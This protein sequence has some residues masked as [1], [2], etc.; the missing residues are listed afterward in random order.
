MSLN[1]DGSRDQ[2]KCTE[3]ASFQLQSSC[4]ALQSIEEKFDTKLEKFK[5]IIIEEIKKN[6][7]K[8][9]KQIIATYKTFAEIV[10]S[11]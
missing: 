4:Q 7:D 6:N 1:N 2:L 8:T 11:T 5:E 3:T 10:R 9:E